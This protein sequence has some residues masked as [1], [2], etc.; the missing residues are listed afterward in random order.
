LARLRRQ[1]QS[2][3]AYI[4]T[5]RVAGGK[6]LLGHDWAARF[7]MF[8]LVYFRHALSFRLFG[9]VILPDHFHAVIQPSQYAT[10]SKIMMKIKGTYAHRYNKLAG[11]SGRFWDPR[12]LDEILQ[13]AAEIGEKLEDMHMNPVRLG[14]APH[15]G[16]YPYSS[17][18]FLFRAAR[19][20][21]VDDLRKGVRGVPAY[22]R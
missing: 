21:I 5:A 15:P 13:D 9:F 6:R 22:L 4:V 2:R 8:T 7:L 19:V 10:I 14:L 18:G 20:E 3:G 1:I 11:R 16:S 12:F 17:Y